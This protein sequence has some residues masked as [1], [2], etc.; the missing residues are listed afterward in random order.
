MSM[1]GAIDSAAAVRARLGME[2]EERPYLS[3]RQMEV[4]ALVAAG[5]PRKEIA[6][7]LGVSLQTIKSHITAIY[8]RTDACSPVGLYRILLFRSL[9]RRL[10]RLP[11]RVVVEERGQARRPY[12]RRDAVLATIREEMGVS[13]PT[14]R[15]QP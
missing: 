6:L 13:A 7:R 2:V 14:I 15:P 5:M 9:T 3:P 8:H 4:A 10:R 12:L 11:Y 1:T